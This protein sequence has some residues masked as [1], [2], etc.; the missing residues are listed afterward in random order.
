MSDLELE[1]RQGILS[2]LSHPN[3]N[4]AKI[5]CKGGW[6]K[7]TDFDPYCAEG[8]LNSSLNDT[9]VIIAVN[10]TT[11]MRAFVRTEVTGFVNHSASG[12]WEYWIKLEEDADKTEYMNNLLAD[13]VE[14]IMYDPLLAAKSPQEVV[15]DMVRKLYED[16]TEESPEVIEELCHGLGPGEELPESEFEAVGIAD[17]TSKPDFDITKPINCPHCGG[18]HYAHYAQ[19]SKDPNRNDHS[20]AYYTC[21]IAGTK[22]CALEG[23]I[24]L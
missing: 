22:I 18:T 21:P 3:V 16:K 1:L 23:K 12:K 20:V 14:K 7:L 11:E 17:L 10:N 8:I 4:E 6:I 2:V 5:R 13:T 24:V 19:D 9:F 15:S